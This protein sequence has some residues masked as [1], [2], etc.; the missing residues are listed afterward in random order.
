[1]PG[2]IPER[3]GGKTDAYIS[4]AQHLASPWF[5]CHHNRD[6]FLGSQTLCHPIGSRTVREMPHAD[7]I[8]DPLPSH[9]GGLHPDGIAFLGQTMPQLLS[10]LTRPKT[11]HL[12]TV[13]SLGRLWQ[14]LTR[15]T[16]PRL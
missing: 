4:R 2:G 15:T 7:P 14:H 10:L 1:M 3:R 6:A 16:R 13:A 12:H 11:P 9:Y 5:F 8:P